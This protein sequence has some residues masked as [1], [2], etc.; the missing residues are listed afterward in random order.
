MKKLPMI[1]LV[2][3]L[4]STAAFAQNGGFQGPGAVA[5]STNNTATTQKGG[6]SGPNAS[7]TTVAE[8]LKMRDD[9]WITLRGNIE[10]QIGKKRYLFRD[11]TGTINIEIDRKYWNG[12]TITPTDKVEIQGELDKDWNEVELD[13]KRVTKID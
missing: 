2:V 5:Q 6:F 10:Q 1:A 8:A 9:S 13:V 12:L 7:I 4:S 3:A 11:E